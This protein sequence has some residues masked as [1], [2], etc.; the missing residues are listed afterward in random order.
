MSSSL[1]LADLQIVLG[2]VLVHRSGV[3]AS[4]LKVAGDVVE[5]I[6]RIPVADEATVMSIAE[7]FYFHDIAHVNYD[8]CPS[9]LRQVKLGKVSKKRIVIRVR[10]RDVF[11][12]RE[13]IIPHPLV[14][15]ALDRATTDEAGDL[16]TLFVV[17]ECADGERLTPKPVC[18]CVKREDL[19][20]VFFSL[21]E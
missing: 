16:G 2:K 12:F 19:S 17:D 4:S 7:Q 13:D 20:H 5:R 14:D 3:L 10:F 6:R 18:F 1:K 11:H 9:F 8:I 15:L 21:R